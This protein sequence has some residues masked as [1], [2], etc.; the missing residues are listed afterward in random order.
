MQTGD[1]VQATR[2][3]L[4]VSTGPGD[5]TSVGFACRWPSPDLLLLLLRH[6][7]MVAVCVSVCCQVGWVGLKSL[8]ANVAST[9][10]SVA[11]ESGY[12]IDLGS[13]AVASSLEQQRFEQQLRAGGGAYTG[14]GSNS[15]QGYDNGGGY[16]NHG[17]G[18]GGV[19][20]S[21]S[22]GAGLG[23]SGQHGYGHSP[24]PGGGAGAAAARSNGN[25]FS[26]F[27]D[28]ADGEW[29]GVRWTPCVWGLHLWATS[30]LEAS[31]AGIHAASACQ[32]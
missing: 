31:K 17:H 13:K 8:Y 11:K 10:E 29:S 22:E 20:K 14:F 6:L 9:V 18:V 21:A 23:G 26:G 30:R 28:G 4:C 32:G 12:K 27:D 24:Q 16:G 15:G 25:G 3:Q 19:H 7:V 1:L 2:L 5:C